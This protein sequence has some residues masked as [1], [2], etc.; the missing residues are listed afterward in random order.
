VFESWK[1]VRF[2]DGVVGCFALGL[3]TAAGLV[4]EDE[5]V[6]VPAEAGGVPDRH[7]RLGN[8]V[9]ELRIRQ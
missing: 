2:L 9:E 5:R 8:R 3:D 6:A 7:A 4:A 1:K